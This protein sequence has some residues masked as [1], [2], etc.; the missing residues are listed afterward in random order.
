MRAHTKWFDLV[1][2]DTDFDLDIILIFFSKNGIGH[3]E[4]EVAVRAGQAIAEVR[5]HYIEL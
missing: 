5:A 1:D 2:A 4:L 3:N